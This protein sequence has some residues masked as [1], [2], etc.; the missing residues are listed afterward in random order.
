MC[1]ICGTSLNIYID[2][3]SP[4]CADCGY[5]LFIDQ[6][7]DDDLEYIYQKIDEWFE[8]NNSTI[9]NEEI[10]TFEDL[11]FEYLGYDD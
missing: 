10:N 4:V 2:H 5:F 1:K 3:A 7:E 6:Y 11:D 9:N 8:E